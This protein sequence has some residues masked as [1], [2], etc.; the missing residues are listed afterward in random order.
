MAYFI[1]NTS[2]P[3]FCPCEKQQSF[4]L[5]SI[6]HCSCTF[7]HCHSPCHQPSYKSGMQ[8]IC[9][10]CLLMSSYPDYVKSSRIFLHNIF[11]MPP[12]LS[13]CLS[14][15]L[16]LCLR[17]CT[18]EYDHWGWTPQMQY[19]YLHSWCLSWSLLF[20]SILTFHMVS[21]NLQN[22]PYLPRMP[23]HLWGYWGYCPW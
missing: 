7:L 23:V 1:W 6:P 13:V 5:P 17:Y 10:Y 8:C 2:F 20:L 16:V 3:H 18:S 15:M 22:L 9:H 11:K 19:I 4:T 14:S 21:K 12:S